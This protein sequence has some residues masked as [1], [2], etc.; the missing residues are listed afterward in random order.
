[1]CAP[2][3]ACLCVCVRVC[4]RAPCACAGSGFER[5]AQMKESCSVAISTRRLIR[6]RN[7][8]CKSLPLW[9]ILKYSRHERSRT[10]RPYRTRGLYVPSM[11]THTRACVCVCVHAEPTAPN[12]RLNISLH[13][14]FTLVFSLFSAGVFHGRCS[15]DAFGST[16]VMPT[17]SRQ[18]VRACQP[19]AACRPHLAAFFA[20][21]L[22]PSAPGRA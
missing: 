21:P 13:S 1:M 12:N 17:T 18:A 7:L 16:P 4:M 6:L 11:R 14:F 20:T 19:T 3:A 2:A 10:G 15:G 9:V 8:L 22:P 5:G